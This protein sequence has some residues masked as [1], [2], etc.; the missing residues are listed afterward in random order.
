MEEVLF[1]IGTVVDVETHKEE[2]ERYII[3]GKR[4]YNPNSGR[5]W[6]Y[7][8]VPVNE[9]YYMNCKTQQPYDNNNLYFFNH[10]DIKEEV[11]N[12]VKENELKKSNSCTHEEIPVVA[13][14]RDLPTS[15]EGTYLLEKGNG[16]EAWF[17]CDG[18]DYKERG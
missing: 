9:G 15:F 10:T 3:I 17:R 11:N 8:G 1:N 14:S 5:S 7:I 6:D 4:Q 2:I 16:R 18:V 13:N 12:K